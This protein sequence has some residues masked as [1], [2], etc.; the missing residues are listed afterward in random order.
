MPFSLALL[1]AVCLISTGAI[2]GAGRALKLGFLG[3]SFSLVFFA[4]SAF[5]ASRFRRSSFWAFS[6]AAMASP[7]NWNVG[8]V[9][10]LADLVG[11]DGV[12]K[13][14]LI[15]RRLEAR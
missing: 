3:I 7:G 2:L 13:E 14:M 6:L 10:G 4:A 1:A 11:G 5:S 8:L 15:G 12:G 9:A